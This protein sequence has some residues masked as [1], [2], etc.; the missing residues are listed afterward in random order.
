MLNQEEREEVGAQKRH[1]V[2]TG[3]FA[4]RS[5]ASSCHR[6]WDNQF[7]ILEVKV[8]RTNSIHEMGKDAVARRRWEI[9]MSRQS[10]GKAL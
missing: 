1:R 9:K 10:C 6:G 4:L 2:V 5:S 7:V 3:T 8:E